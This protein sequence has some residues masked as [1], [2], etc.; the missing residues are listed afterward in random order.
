MLQGLRAGLATRSEA[1]VDEPGRT[2]SASTAD[3]MRSVERDLA[4]VLTLTGLLP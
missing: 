2:N 3:S 1:M 4:D